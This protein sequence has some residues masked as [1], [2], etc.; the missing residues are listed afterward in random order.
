MKHDISVKN[1]FSQQ[2]PLKFH[3]GWILE[4]GADTKRL[5]FAWWFHAQRDVIEFI[6]IYWHLKDR[7]ISLKSHT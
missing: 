4:G 2:I 5:E 7:L 6:N 1:V 3:E